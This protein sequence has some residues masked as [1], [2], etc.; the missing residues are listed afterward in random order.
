MTGDT[1]ASGAVGAPVT[2][3]PGTIVGEGGINTPGVGCD[4]GAGTKIVRTTVSCAVGSAVGLGVVC[5]VG[6]ILGFAVGVGVGTAV[7]VGVSTA[8]GCAV[9]SIVGA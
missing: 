6:A 5:A 1:G 8:V 7:G 3:G 9:R 4:V 2:G